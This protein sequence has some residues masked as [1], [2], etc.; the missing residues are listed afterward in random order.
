VDGKACVINEVF[1]DGLGACIGECPAG[2][3]EFEEK[4]AAP[5]DERAVMARLVAQGENTVRAHLLHLKKHH[6]T[7]Y[8]AQGLQYLQE[9]GIKMDL[10]AD[11]DEGPNARAADLNRG[12]NGGDKPAAVVQCGDGL[13]SA[14]VCPGSMAVSFEPPD[15]GGS[16]AAASC[17]THWPVQLRLLNPQA[18]CFRNA[19]VVLAADCSAY[20]YGDFHRR[21][22]KNRALAIACP[23]LDAEKEKYID[24]LTMMLD[25]AAVNTLTVITMEVPCCTGLLAL[26]RQAADRA[27][28]KVPVKKIVISIRGDVLREEWLC[29]APGGS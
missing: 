6:E 4:E 16:G 15:N 23:K 14:G 5:Y 1:C 29:G 19:D 9:H 20:A 21:F 2:A 11:G 24:K 8:F 10:K 17:L 26:A 28:R 7:A 18:S 27:G 12:R 3:I 13:K 25:E 22:L